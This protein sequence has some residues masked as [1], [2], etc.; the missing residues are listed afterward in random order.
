MDVQLFSAMK[1]RAIRLYAAG[2]R[3]HAN[4]L[5]AAVGEIGELDMDAWE[6]QR[7]D[8]RL[9]LRARLTVP[10]G[11]TRKDALPPIYDVVLLKVTRRGMLLRG[12]ENVPHGIVDGRT[13]AGYVQEWWCEPVMDQ[14]A[15]SARSA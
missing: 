14:G 2:T 3:R 13:I 9:Q 6:T 12:I 1:V 7:P 5:R 10:A 4:E 11:N 8:R 15:G